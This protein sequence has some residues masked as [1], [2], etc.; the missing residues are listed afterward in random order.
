MK[1]TRRILTKKELAELVGV[2]GDLVDRWMAKGLPYTKQ[3][4]QAMFDRVKVAEWFSKSNNMA[5]KYLVKLLPQKENIPTPQVSV[6]AGDTVQQ[7]TSMLERARAVEQASFRAWQT[8]DACLKGLMEEQYMK[9]LDQLRKAEKD[10]P[11][12]QIAAADA[13][14]KSVIINDITTI[15]KTLSD[16]LL[17]MPQSLPILLEGK[18]PAEI[19]AVLKQK[20]DE[21]LQCCSDDLSK[22][23]K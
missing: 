1:D 2:S 3:G 16:H 11:A 10:W 7:F 6:K 19:Q 12:I 4:R 15:L 18:T 9:S 17:S 21:A 20:I 22:L 13:L 8:C 23:A 14:P 5:T